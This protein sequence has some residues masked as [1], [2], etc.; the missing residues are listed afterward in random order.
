M[1]LSVSKNRY[2]GPVQAVVLDWAGTVVDHGCMGP[3]AVFVEV[4]KE[5][6]IEISAQEARK[7][8]GVEKKEHIQKLCALD[9]VSKAWQEKY[10]ALPG[11]IEVDKLYER[12]ARLMGEAICK[13]GDLIGGV[14]PTV[15]ALRDMDIK[16]GSSTGYVKEMMDVLVPIARDKGYAPDA[17]FCSSDVPQGRPFPWMCYLNA[18]ALGVY[19]MAAMV[20]VG[21]TIADIQEGLNAGMWTVGI[22]RTGNEM[23]LT[24]EDLEVLDPGVRRAK[25][26]TITKAFKAA[27]AHYVLEQAG[28]L[29]PVIQEINRRLA[30]G[31]MP[32][33]VC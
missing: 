17:V 1:S 10:G 19:P 27:N 5:R 26:Q 7:F 6:G 29:L 15:Q 13:H 33:G 12:T 8:M 3:A 9:S 11:Q 16:I 14:V 24:L 2:S 22:T 4:F 23:G 21:D 20:K 28:D 32:P 25:I 18:I 31:E 30:H